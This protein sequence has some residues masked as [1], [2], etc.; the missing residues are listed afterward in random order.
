MRHALAV[1]LL[2][3]LP[4]QAIWA[5]CAP[6]C[7]HEQGAAALHP[8]HHAHEHEAS[9][10][11]GDTASLTDSLPGMDDRDCHACHGACAALVPAI[12]PAAAAFA[13]P[14]PGAD[15]RPALPAPPLFRPERP[16]WRA[17][18]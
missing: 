4:L 9:G 1:L 2:V 3:L 17:L 5:A 10:P 12:A 11:D 18:A 16:K 14:E 15:A 6:Y 13:G 7:Q 8:G